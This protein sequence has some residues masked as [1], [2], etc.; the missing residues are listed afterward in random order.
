MQVPTLKVSPSSSY[1]KPIVNRTTQIMP[2]KPIHDDDPN[3]RNHPPP[4]Q[5]QTCVTDNIQIII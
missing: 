4:T 2:H 1:L 3:L 5:T